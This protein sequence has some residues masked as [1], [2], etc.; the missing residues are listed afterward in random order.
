VWIHSGKCLKK[1][2][3]SPPQ[4]ASLLLSTHTLTIPSKVPTSQDPTHGEVQHAGCR[5]LGPTRVP[6]RCP[7]CSRMSSG[8]RF[9]SRPKPTGC[10]FS[11]VYS[12][13]WINA[14]E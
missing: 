2:L 12:W 1:N 3:G 10:T 8:G 14:V 6:W 13:H 7:L 4:P 5:P 9:D 11:S